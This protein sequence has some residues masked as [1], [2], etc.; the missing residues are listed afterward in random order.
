MGHDVS[1]EA[2]VGC[3]IGCIWLDARTLGVSELLVYCRCPD[4]GISDLP[5]QAT[6]AADGRD[7]SALF[8]W[9]GAAVR[10]RGWDGWA[11]ARVSRA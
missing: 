7:C 9:K 11:T 10:G 8:R 3:C 2:C 4:G 5:S 6:L 1:E